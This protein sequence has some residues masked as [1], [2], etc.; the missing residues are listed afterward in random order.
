MAHDI[1]HRP[2]G[3]LHR[4]YLTAAGLDATAIQ[5]PLIG[6]AS[7]ATQVFSENPDARDLGGAAASGIDAAGGISV[8]WDMPRSPD[9]MAWG[10]AESYGFAWRDQL[11]DMVE[12]W[13]RQEALDGL[14]LVGDAPETLAGMVMAA[15]RLNVPAVVVTAGGKKW[16]ES[17][18]NHGNNQRKKNAPDALMIFSNLMAGTSKDGGKGNDVT[19]DGLVVPEDRC[20]RSLDAVLEALGV[21][22]PGMSTAPV[23]SVRRHELA[24]ASGQRAV[25]LAKSGYAI[26]RVL[27]QNAFANAV[28]IYSSLGGP[29]EVAVH[30][31][32]IAHEAGVA[33]SMDFF[34][35]IGAQTPRFVSLDGGSAEKPTTLE[36]LDSAGGVWAVLGMLKDRILPTTTVSGHGALELAKNSSVK[37]T[38]IVPKKPLEKASGLGT[39][40]GSLALRGS[41]FHR[42]QVMPS[43]ERIQGP[44]ALFEDERSAVAALHQNKIRKGSVIVVRGQGPRGGPGLRMLR[45]LPLAL[46]LRGW[47]KIFPVVT[48]GRLPIKPSGLF[49]SCVSPES[50]VSGPLAVMR[51]G[52]IVEIDVPARR[53]NVKL[54]S[55]E[56]QVRLARWRPSEGRGKR[57]FLERYARC[58]SEVS[59][60]AVL[61]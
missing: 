42:H 57:D 30:L 31:M 15:A 40:T 1:R 12:S 45:L 60:G 38:R 3:L 26:R 37:D 18:K 51:T 17:A 58:V 6:V 44:A 32:A 41:F 2:E 7:S 16:S 39:L 24:F 14:V 23:Q 29:T 52:D 47:N 59:E 22:L 43:L 34:D 28:R 21:T 9:V 53:L 36:E 11:A 49:V 46:E 25:E 8:R 55:T 35:R 20:A 56:M 61:K 48:D 27:T 33:L 50:A 19:H 10:H 13:V 4:L 5:K 54:T